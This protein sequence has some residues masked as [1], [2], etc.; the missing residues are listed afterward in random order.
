MPSPILPISSS[1]ASAGAPLTYGFLPEAFSRPAA[2][3]SELASKPGGVSFQPPQSGAGGRPIHTFADFLNDPLFDRSTQE[4]VARLD[5]LARLAADHPAQRSVAPTFRRFRDRLL[6]E[7]GRYFDAALPALHGGGKRGLAEFCAMLKNESIDGDVR[8]TA[9]RELAAELDA[10]A[11]RAGL[12]L[13][14]APM[15]LRMAQGGLHAELHQRIERNTEQALL[16]AWREAAKFGRWTTKWTTDMEPHGIQQLRRELELPGAAD[17]DFI[18]NARL[19]PRW[20]VPHARRRVEDLVDPVILA[21]QMAV[22]FMAELQVALRKSF[23]GDLGTI[24]PMRHKHL[25]CVQRELDG[26]NTRYGGVRMTSISQARDDDF[27]RSAL[28]SDPALIAL[29]LMRE[30]HRRHLCPAPVIEPLVRWGSSTDAAVLSHV[31]GRIF[32]VEHPVPGLPDAE[33]RPAAIADLAR[34]AAPDSTDPQASAN[35]DW[36]ASLVSHLIAAA[37]HDELASFPA[38]WIDN[39][40]NATALLRRLGPEGRRSWLA[41]GPLPEPSNTLVQQARPTVEQEET[42]LA[43]DKAAR[44]AR[45]AGDLAAAQ[46]HRALESGDSDSLD[47]ALRALGPFP[48]RL[49]ALLQTQSQGIGRPLHHVLASGHAAS[50]ALLIRAMEQLRVERH[51]SAREYATLLTGASSLPAL[52]HPAALD[53]WLERMA[54]DVRAGWLDRSVAIKALTPSTRYG[55]GVSL[56]AHDSGAPECLRQWTDLVIRSARLGLVPSDEAVDILRGWKDETQPTGRQSSP[57]LRQLLRQGRHEAMAALL[58]GYAEAG[59]QGVV[60]GPGLMRLLQAKSDRNDVSLLQL[61]AEQ[62]V[63]AQES[64]RVVQAFMSAA[65]VARQRGALS[66]AEYLRLISEGDGGAT[67]LRSLCAQPYPQRLGVYLKG[68]MSAAQSGVIPVADLTALLTA[69]GADKT[70]VVAPSSEAHTTLMREWVQDLEALQAIDGKT[71]RKL[72]A[73]ITSA[74]TAS[75]RQGS[76]PSLFQRVGAHMVAGFRSR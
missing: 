43:A 15:A 16:Q 47:A 18:A 7:N 20:L 24:D 38:S 33:R 42:R 5:E 58:D 50:A 17:E 14:R 4:I 68:L 6:R 36:R 65:L 53:V 30:M 29:D 37:P 55:L 28:V 62:S 46:I 32:F 27:T 73:E 9:V 34:M 74:T 45:R 54:K 61:A 13:M 49:A 26:L 63:N 75:R 23:K 2:A 41:R 35:G 71:A 10:C 56:W 1:L 21:G 51:L 12:A 64:D 60:T 67:V 57:L 31:G 66:S 11:P 69:T 72:A 22:D 76:S 8:R 3:P 19:I 39:Q 44:E 48:K 52:A 25:L 59:R 70:P 40:K